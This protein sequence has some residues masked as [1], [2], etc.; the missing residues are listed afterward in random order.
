MPETPITQMRIPTWIKKEVK[1]RTKNF[2]KFTI[3]A[4]IEKLNKPKTN[5]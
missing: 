1:K 3:Q 4:I 2:T 5:G